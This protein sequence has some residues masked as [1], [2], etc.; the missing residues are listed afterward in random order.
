MPDNFSGNDYPISYRIVI[1][2]ALCSCLESKKSKES[3][4]SY[5]ND[6][7]SFIGY[8]KSGKQK[9]DNDFLRLEG[10]LEVVRF[11]HYKKPDC[12]DPQILS[13]DGIGFVII[14]RSSRQAPLVLYGRPKNKSKKDR[15]LGFLM[16]IKSIRDEF[17]TVFRYISSKEPWGNI[18]ES[19]KAEFLKSKSRE[20]F[21]KEAS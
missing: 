17:E 12:F 20:K 21:D 19:L 13:L 14:D 18:E 3:L 8:F 16:S 4:S 11:Y 7:E 15:R 10:F 1:C 6:L 9:D 2:H 5:L